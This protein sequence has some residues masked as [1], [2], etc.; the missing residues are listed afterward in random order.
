MTEISQSDQLKAAR[1]EGYG[2]FTLS[3][4][5][6]GDSKSFEIKHLSYDAYLEFCELARPIL[7]ACSSALDMGNNNGEFKLEFNPMAVDFASLL[8]LAGK[9][10]PRMAWLCCRQSEPK[11]T[12]EEVKHLGY[13]PQAL[14]SVV[15]QQ[16]KHNEMVKEFADF[17]PKIVEQLTALLPAAQE[18]AAPIPAETTAPSE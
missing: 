5:A 14:L 12:I 13:R 16:I 4:P 8:K 2:T 3:N 10:L 6:S 7:T 1:N 15:L 17:F 18:A 9:E 11:I